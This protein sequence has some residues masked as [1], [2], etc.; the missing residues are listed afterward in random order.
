M[1][2]EG[3]SWKPHRP[4]GIERRVFVPRPNVDGHGWNLAP[5]VQV[6]GTVAPDPDR[7]DILRLG[8]EVLNCES[9]QR[10]MSAYHMTDPLRMIGGG[11]IDHVCDAVKE[12]LRRS[13]SARAGSGG[14]T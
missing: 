5:I 8:I 10:V 12:Q 14:K 9:G 1:S 4:W 7:P 6:L 11:Y 3:P 13:L 2:D